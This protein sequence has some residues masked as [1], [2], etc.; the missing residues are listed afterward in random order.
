MLVYAKGYNINENLCQN[1]PIEQK[2]DRE[3]NEEL[4]CQVG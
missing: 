3:L 1:I 2:S 4:N